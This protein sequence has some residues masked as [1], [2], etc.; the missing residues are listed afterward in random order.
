MKKSDIKPGM[1]VV[2]R[3]GK[4]YKLGMNINGVV[5]LV[6]TE[7]YVELDEYNPDLTSNVDDLD[8]SRCF[9]IMQ[10]YKPKTVKDNFSW[11]ILD[12]D[13]VWGRPEEP[14]VVVVSVEDIAR[15]MKVD[16]HYLVIQDE[17]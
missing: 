10:V 13:L 9:D 8:I 4:A 12:H 14:K 16:P 17:R 2:T 5:C 7:G 3:G 15:L 1:L 11:N 6:R